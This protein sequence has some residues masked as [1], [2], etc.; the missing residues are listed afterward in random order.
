MSKKLFI[1]FSSI[2]ASFLRTPQLSHLCQENQRARNCN[3]CARSLHYELATRANKALCFSLIYA[4]PGGCEFKRTNAKLQFVQQNEKCLQ[5]NCGAET[6]DQ[7]QLAKTIKSLSPDTDLLTLGVRLNPEEIEIGVKS[8]ESSL[9]REFPAEKCRANMAQHTLS[10]ESYSI[11]ED[12]KVENCD[13]KSQKDFVSAL[14]LAFFLVGLVVCVFAT[15]KIYCNLRQDL[16]SSR[17]K[18]S[19]AKNSKEDRLLS[20]DTL[21]YNST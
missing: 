16:N 2:S 21:S 20:E 1:L 8:M 17:E 4:C 13:P 9:H 10:L 6:L 18:I 15:L 12:V 19:H 11:R 3:I 14:A 7:G 5:A